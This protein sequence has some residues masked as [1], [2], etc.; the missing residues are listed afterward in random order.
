MQ[1]NLLEEGAKPEHMLWAM[2]FLKCFP[3]TGEGCSAAGTAKKG[4]VDPKIWQKYIWPTV[5]ALSDL[6]REVVS[7]T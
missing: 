6:E 3:K 1:N 5:Y 7:F 4:A 2:Y